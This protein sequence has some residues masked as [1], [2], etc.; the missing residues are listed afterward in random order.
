MSPRHSRITLVIPVRNEE[1]SLPH[2]LASVRAQTRRP[3]AVIFVDAGSTDRTN[4][5]LSEACRTC[6]GWSV[7]AAGEAMPGTARNVGIEAAQTEW[8]ALTDAGIE[9][10][11]H[12]LDRMTRFASAHSDV[13]VVY[14]TYRPARESWLTECAALVYVAAATPSSVG[15]VRGP[16][17][18]SC[19]LRKSVWSRA[20]GFSDLRA[21]EDRIFMREVAALGVNAVTSP[22]AIVQWQVQPTIRTTFNRFRAYSRVNALAGEQRYWH[23]RVLRMYAIAGSSLLLSTRKRWFAL[24]PLA[25]GVFRVW[26]GVWDRR[27][28]RDVHWTLDPRRLATC[29]LIT[30]VVDAATFTGWIEAMLEHEDA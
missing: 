30:A 11:P 27:E 20:G 18:A 2:L 3:D 14:G 29:A 19:L 5:I 17:I 10:D 15:P 12:W 28:G 9:L 16:S 25:G 26:R 1:R 24:V 8:I 23:H 7:V 13:E 6:T 22:E 21:A 4:A